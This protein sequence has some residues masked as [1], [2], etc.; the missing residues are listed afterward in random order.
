[1]I[2]RS[3]TRHVRDRNWFAVGIDFVIAIVGVFIGIQVA[4]WKDAG[5][6]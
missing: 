4:I 2:M 6:T 1:M 5:L 3:I